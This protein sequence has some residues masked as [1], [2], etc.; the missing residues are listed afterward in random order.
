MSS[1]TACPLDC[2]DACSID[3]VDGKLKGSKDSYTHGYLCPH[4]NHYGNHPQIALPRYKGAEVTMEE[5]LNIL[6]D[7]IAGVSDPSQIL[8]YRGRGNFALMQQVSDHFFA[9]YGATLTE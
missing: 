4:L 5:A 2:Y 6:E 8:H 7:K 3:V 9:S 1:K